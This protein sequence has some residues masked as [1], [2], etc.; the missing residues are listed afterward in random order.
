MHD[1]D[2]GPPGQNNAENASQ[3]E[4]ANF[5]TKEQFFQELEK[6]EAARDI[7]WQTRTNDLLKQQ[8][9]EFLKKI[10]LLQEENDKLKQ[11]NHK[12]SQSLNNPGN[13]QHSSSDAEFE[14]ESLPSCHKMDYENDFQSVENKKK[15][16]KRKN[17]SKNSET[18]SNSGNET[19]DPKI[20][21]TGFESSS[22]ISN[23]TKT[24][25]PKT[26][27]TPQHNNTPPTN[28]DPQDTNNTTK[29]LRVPP[30]ILREKDKYNQIT[31]HFKNNNIN[32]GNASTVPEGVKFHPP[33]PLDYSK[34]M[35]Y[36]D[37]NKIQYHSFRTAEE[38]DL[39]V[40]LRGVLEV[41][42]ENKIK[43]DL[44]DLGFTPS[45]VVCW[46]NKQGKRMPLALVILPKTQKNIFDL[47]FL[48]YM[49]IRVEAQRSQRQTTQCHRCQLFGHT[50]FKCTASM[51][52]F[53]CAQEHFSSDCPVKGQKE[54]LSCAN[55]NA[56]HPA[57]SKECPK[58]PT[59][60]I[61]SKIE[62]QKTTNNNFKWGTQ[63]NQTIANNNKIP[64]AEAIESAIRKTME[65]SM[66]SFLGEFQKVM[67]SQVSNM[68]ST[69]SLTAAHG[70]TK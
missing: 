24:N 20:Q 59:N 69:F 1:L 33:T 13:V 58:N 23:P 68:L 3:S 51:K 46:F 42:D 54:A 52:C 30:I 37:K 53:R 41:W 10:K 34:M 12:V 36:L 28:T 32:F 27:Q 48:N 63:N 11:I 67:Q 8:E 50:Q 26:T 47:D 7:M 61:N 21:K 66:E 39:H 31:S 14:I 25:P 38:K 64:G 9:Q 60:L 56:N 22:P 4:S 65:S 43:T 45:K 35:K 5:I 40:V 62:Q 6:R 17:Q 19:T 55:C 18:N 44:E 57:N 29:K 2:N 70:N 15:L 49:R 16:R